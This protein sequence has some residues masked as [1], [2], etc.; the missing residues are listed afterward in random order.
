MIFRTFLICSLIAFSRLGQWIYSLSAVFSKL[1]NNGMIISSS[2]ETFPAAS[3]LAPEEIEDRV[4][5]NS[6]IN[7]KA[8]ILDDG[9][10]NLLY[11]DR[12]VGLISS[13]TIEFYFIEDN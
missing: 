3:S 10:G 13:S 4:T 8:F 12:K 1:T 9:N 11:M 2:C 6:T 7:K 5:G